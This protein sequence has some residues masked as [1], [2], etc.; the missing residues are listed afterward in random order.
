MSDVATRQYDLNRST[1]GS[2][3]AKKVIIKKTQAAEKDMKITSEKERYAFIKKE[4]LI[5]LQ[6]KE[7]E[8]KRDITRLEEKALDTFKELKK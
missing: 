1:L 2:I 5:F 8:M 3:L 7:R 6:I 4:R